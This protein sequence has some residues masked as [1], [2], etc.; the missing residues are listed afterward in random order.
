MKKMKIFPVIAILLLLGFAACKKSGGS[1]AGASGFSHI[2]FTTGDSLSQ[3]R[4]N[5]AAAAAG[6]KIVFAGGGTLIPPSTS[7][8]VVN[9]VDI[10]DTATH[11]WTSGQ[12][13]EARDYVAAAATGGKILFAGGENASTGYSKAVDIYDAASGNWTTGNLS[14]GRRNLAA[15]ATGSKILFAGGFDNTDLLN[16]V[17]IYDAGSGNWTVSQLSEARCYL[18]GAAAGS[19]IAFGGGAK[20]NDSLSSTVDI[21]DVNTGKWTVS[22]LSVPRDNLAAAAAGS[23]IVFAGGVVYNAATTKYA[24]STA[25][26]I[27][28][29]NSG[30]WTTAQLSEARTQLAAAGGGELIPIRGRRRQQQPYPKQWISIM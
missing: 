7:S 22:K 12:L 21:Y 26:D 8:I 3:A 13:S 29:V 30:Q 5:A 25:V 18:A 6:S 4:A 16:T 2:T 20:A 15:A 11:A 1:P 10:Y 23:K 19:K 24:P 17:D 14:V 27:Y 28:D 9:T